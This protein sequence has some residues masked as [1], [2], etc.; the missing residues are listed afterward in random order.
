MAKTGARSLKTH[1][2]AKKA[3]AVAAAKHPHRKAKEAAKAKME[4]TLAQ[5]VETQ[6]R[7]ANSY[8]HWFQLVKE[9]FNMLNLILGA[10]VG[11]LTLLFSEDPLKIA[12]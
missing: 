6:K 10:L 5:K 12:L 4:P 7:S 1:E 9:A 11:M 3:A 2:K 8:F